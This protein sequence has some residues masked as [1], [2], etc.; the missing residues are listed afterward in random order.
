MI[1]EGK[2]KVNRKMEEPY[3]ILGQRRN[4]YQQG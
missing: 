1:R 2:K 4:S 3:N